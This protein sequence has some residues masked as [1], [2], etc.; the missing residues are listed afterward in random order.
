[1]HF[2]IINVLW[3]TILP[4][5]IF[6]DFSNGLIVHNDILNRLV[7]MFAANF[8]MLVKLNVFYIYCYSDDD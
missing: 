1:M 7:L 2:D 5:C 8:G 4:H 6:M 3:P